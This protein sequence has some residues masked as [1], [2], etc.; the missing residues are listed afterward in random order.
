[1]TRTIDLLAWTGARIG[2]PPGWERIVRWFAPPERFRGTPAICLERDGMAF[3]AQPWVPLGWHVAMFGT[4]EPELRSLM[5]ALLPAGGVA[6]DVGAN[7]GWH[8][9]L[10]ARLAGANGRVLAVEANPSVR[11]VLDRNIALNRFSNVEVVPVIVSDHEGAHGF[12]SPPAEDQASGDGYVVMGNVAQSNVIQV[13]SRRLD[14]IAAASRLER[15]DFLK[16]DVE[17]WEWPALQGAEETIARFRPNIV[18]EYN[19]EYVS[20]GGGTPEAFTGFLARHRYQGFAIG[21]NWASAIEAGHWPS[22]ANVL[23]VPGR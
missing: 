7:V 19:D 8:T 14:T 2:K 18:F 1:M 12:F 11:Q 16:I 6:I 9:L 5:R 10:M 17:G 23:A 20:R 4:Y 13:E 22:C 21:R 3:V 15:L